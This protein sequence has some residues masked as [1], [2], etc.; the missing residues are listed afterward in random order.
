MNFISSNDG[1][2]GFIDRSLVSCCVINPQH[3]RL[4][5]MF[6]G[7]DN[8]TPCPLESYSFPSRYNKQLSPLCAHSSMIILNDVIFFAFASLCMYWGCCYFA[9][10][11]SLRNCH[12]F[13]LVNFLFYDVPSCLHKFTTQELIFGTLDKYMYQFLSQNF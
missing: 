11:L 1:D 12:I 9:F 6:D 10:Y 2:S 3:P 7:L 13:A 4:S 8:R 5:L